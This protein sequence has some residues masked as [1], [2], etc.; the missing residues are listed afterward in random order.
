MNNLKNNVQLIGHLGDAPEIKE[1]EGGRLLAKFS[2]ATNEGYKNAQGEKVEKTLWHNIVCFGNTAKFINDYLDLKKGSE[3][4]V[5]GKID[6]NT[7]ENEGGVKIKATNIV[8]DEIVKLK[9]PTKEIEVQGAE[10]VS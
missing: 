8:I 4:I 9:D 7:Y 3:V 2:L 5:S 10:E 1:L 6:Y